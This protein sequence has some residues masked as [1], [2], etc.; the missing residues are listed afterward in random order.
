MTFSLRQ[1]FRNVRSRDTRKLLKLIVYLVL[2]RVNPIV[3]L[4]QTVLYFIN[5]ILRLHD[6]ILED[7]DFSLWGTNWIL[8]SLILKQYIHDLIVVHY[9]ILWIPIWAKLWL[10][11]NLNCLLQC[12]SFNLILCSK[13]SARMWT[14]LF[15]CFA[16]SRF[17]QFLSSKELGLKLIFKVLYQVVVVY[18]PL[19]WDSTAQSTHFRLVP[20]EIVGIIYWQ[21]VAYLWIH[22]NK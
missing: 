10:V 12:F 4:F 6:S 21:K 3:W 14:L 5:C 19:T 2:N 16:L 17:M 22:Y 1:I 7:L 20:A 8:L 11:L 15:S 9:L 18:F 13:H